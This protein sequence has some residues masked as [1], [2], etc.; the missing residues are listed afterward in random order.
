MEDKRI[1]S[2]RVQ[3]P[4]LESKWEYQGA[5]GRKNNGPAEIKSVITNVLWHTAT[6][7]EEPVVSSVVYYTLTT[8]SK[9]GYMFSNFN[10]QQW[11]PDWKLLEAESTEVRTIEAP[12]YAPTRPVRKA[13]SQLLF[14]GGVE[15]FTLPGVTLTDGEAQRIIEAAQTASVVDTLSRALP[16]STRG[17]ISI[18]WSEI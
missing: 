13:R 1:T 18:T 15:I 6:R 3:V 4:K 14:R 2:V 17:K 16:D 9:S 7:F 10:L 8:G 12:P 5:G 11:F